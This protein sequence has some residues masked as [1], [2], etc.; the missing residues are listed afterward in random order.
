LHLGARLND[1][2]G[3]I[4]QGQGGLRPIER[5]DGCPRD[6]RGALDASTWACCVATRC[7]C[8]IRARAKER[9]TS[10]RRRRAT[11]F[12]ALL[13]IGDP[14]GRFGPVRRIPLADVVYEDRLGQA[15]R[16]M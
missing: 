9:R 5:V 11:A 12:C 6:R 13:L 2:A 4:E 1:P 15:Y 16:N 3:T 7:R 14:I 10:A 8:G